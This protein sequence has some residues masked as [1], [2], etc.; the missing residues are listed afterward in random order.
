MVCAIV[1][2]FLFF[3]LS[4]F[5]IIS[6]V[7]YFHVLVVKTRTEAEESFFLFSSCGFIFTKPLL[8][9]VEGLDQREVSVQMT[10]IMELRMFDHLKGSVRSVSKKCCPSS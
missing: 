8:A 1:L 4:Y 3:C 6:F 10:I 9:K 5:F 2:L 7:S